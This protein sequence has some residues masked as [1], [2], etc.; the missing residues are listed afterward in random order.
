MHTVVVVHWHITMLCIWVGD[1]WQVTI[2]SPFAAVWPC[3][4]Y[5]VSTFGEAWYLLI[6]PHIHFD[7]TIDFIHFCI[8]ELLL[9]ASMQQSDYKWGCHL[10]CQ[11]QET[12]L[13]K[14][15]KWWEFV[16]LYC[17]ECLEDTFKFSKEG[18]SSLGGISIGHWFGCR[19]DPHLYIGIDLAIHKI[20][21]E[22]IVI[23]VGWEDGGEVWKKLASY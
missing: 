14:E 22:S 12:I 8:Q 11:T 20:R 15:C 10:H 13:F 7:K 19:G 18:A 5:D 16:V 21:C 3:A 6:F 17:W 9:V 4:V 2:D 1:H 23:I